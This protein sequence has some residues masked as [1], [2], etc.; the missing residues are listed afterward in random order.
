MPLWL[1]LCVVAGLLLGT[2][3]TRFFAGD[4]LSI[5]NVEGVGKL[6]YLLQIIDNQYVD[7]VNINDLIE[8][9]MPRVLAELDPHSTYIPAEQTEEASEE[10][11]GSFSGIGVRF[12][13]Q[14]DTVTVM[15]V[16]KGGPSE[17]GGLQ[18]G[19]RLLSADGQTLIGL[20]NS[21]IMKMLKGPE[22]TKVELSVLRRGQK[23]PLSYTITRG[24]IPVQSIEAYFILN[25]TT[26]YIMIE[27]FGET[28]YAEMLMALTEMSLQGME[29]LI[30]DLRG[31]RGGYLQSAVQMVNEF[32]PA[33]R[34]IVYTEGRKSP[35]E[36]VRSN[37]RGS[38]QQ[39]P[40]VVLTDE[41]SA[42]ASEIFAGAIQDNDRGV[43]VGRRSFGKGL[44]QAP[45]ELNDGSVVRLTVARYYTPSGRCIQRSYTSGEDKDYENDWMLRYERG[46]FFSADS[47]KQEGPAYKTRLGREVYGG[48]GIMP[49]YFVPEDTT[50]FT[51][52]YREAVYNGL[53]LQFAFQ[54]TDQHR[55]ELSR[56]ETVDKLAAWLG[57]QR[58][59]ELFA[60]YADHNGLLRRNLQLRQSSPLIERNLTASII[61]NISGQKERL[62]YISQWDNTI[63]KALQ[64]IEQN[65]TVPQAPSK[66]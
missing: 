44:V 8:K 47:I 16:I 28:T 33:D 15:N 27:S 66:Q 20:D 23:R 50:L 60:T 5:I 58:L 43:V 40:L 11:R 13:V 63:I 6:N 24:E 17:R 12:T 2:F 30:I 3:Y 52:Y 25:E 56:L 64:L 48:G 26:G 10:L 42:S 62:Q 41:G 57:N 37:G 51:S 4:R 53:L 22:G 35:R 61:Y 21:Q 45:I 36:D 18:A 65:E 59:V 54:F 49:D 14:G 39:L 7:T 46:E 9:T 31:N 19:D 34:L 55:D 29:S 32:L 1:S 38:F